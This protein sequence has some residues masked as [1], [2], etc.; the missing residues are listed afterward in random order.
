[1]SKFNSIT[2]ESGGMLTSIRLRNFKCYRDSGEVP[3]APLTIIIGCNNSGKSALIQPLLALK[4]T[5][6]D[7]SWTARLVT[8]GP[9]V[10]L[11][12]FYDLVHGGHG[13][14]APGNVEFDFTRDI[15]EGSGIVPPRGFNFRESTKLHVEFGLNQSANRIEVA[16]LK[17]ADSKGGVAEFSESEQKWSAKTVKRSH[18]KLLVPRFKNFLIDMSLNREFA[19]VNSANTAEQ[20]AESMG[21]LMDEY[22]SLD[23]QSHAWTHIFFGVVHVSPLRSRVPW[24]TGIGRRYSSE[25]GIGGENLIRVLCNEEKDSNGKTLMDRVDD[26]MSKK[27]TAIS[28]IRM[29]DVDRAGRVRS[30]IAD[31]PTGHK[32]INVA[33][34]GEGISQILPIITSSLRDEGETLIIEQPEIHLHPAAQTGLGDLFV[35]SVIKSEFGRQIIVETHSE[36]LLLRV[37][38]RIAKGDI[39]PEKVSILYVERENNETSVTRLNLNGRGHFDKWP[40]GFFDEAYQEAMALALAQPVED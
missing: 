29:Q 35:D 40:N 2:G 24:F 13:A 37:R 34:M 11:G 32:G 4:Q 33:G 18:K 6:T 10:D 15:P 22:V 26:W 3:L 14:T 31:D 17:F 27:T 21:P 8:S 28:K 9:L 16:S 25:T 20:F 36:H 23:M 12:G 5:L 1:M 39:P 30:L 7:P 19:K 38:T